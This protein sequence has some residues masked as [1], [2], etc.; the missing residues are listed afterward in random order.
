MKQRT[1]IFVLQ[2]W[3]LLT[4]IWKEKNHN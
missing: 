3:K 2:F 1:K 4:I